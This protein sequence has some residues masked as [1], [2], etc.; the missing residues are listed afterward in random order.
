[1]QVVAVDE[2]ITMPAGTATFFLGMNL[3]VVPRNQW[4]PFLIVIESVVVVIGVV[5]VLSVDKLLVAL[6]LTKIVID[7]TMLPFTIRLIFQEIDGKTSK[8]YVLGHSTLFQG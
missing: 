4:V 6:V 8:I 2:Q 1:V 3:A 5:F 7:D